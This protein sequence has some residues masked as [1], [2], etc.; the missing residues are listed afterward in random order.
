[1]EVQIVLSR[2]ALL[3]SSLD[4]LRKWLL[5]CGAWPCWDRQADACKEPAYDVATYPRHFGINPSTIIAACNPQ[6]R[7]RRCYERWQVWP[8]VWCLVN[9]GR[10]S[11]RGKMMLP[12]WRPAG[13]HRLAAGLL[14][15]RL[16][17]RLLRGRP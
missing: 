10:T 7:G 4:R 12:K 13:P 11:A 5:A 14:P 1:M 17:R 3:F 2:L 16:M 8:V 15:L 6:D 9:A